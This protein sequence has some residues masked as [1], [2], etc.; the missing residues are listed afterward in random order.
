MS[1]L[2]DKKKNREERMEFVRFWAEYVR[3]HPDKEWSEQ[4]KDLIDSQ[5]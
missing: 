1:E 3:E 5:M 4:Q 2:F